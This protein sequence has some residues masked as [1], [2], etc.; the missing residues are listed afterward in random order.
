[1]KD[2]AASAAGQVA[3]AALCQDEASLHRSTPMDIRHC[4]L[5]MALALLAGCGSPRPPET[6][7]RPDPQAAATRR[8][9]APTRVQATATRAEPAPTGWKPAQPTGNAP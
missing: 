4:L 7:R 6:E 3:A 1:V 5:P 8:D 2:T 9:D